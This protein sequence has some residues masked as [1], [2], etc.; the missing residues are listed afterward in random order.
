MRTADATSPVVGA[1]EILAS[2]IVFS[3]LYLL[4]GALWLYLMRREVQH[5]PPPAPAAPADRLVPA[6]GPTDA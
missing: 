4:L 6:G 1:P 2:I 5:G 3:L